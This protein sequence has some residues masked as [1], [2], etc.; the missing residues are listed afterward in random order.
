M[1]FGA[2]EEAGEWVVG[3]EEDRELL[4][5]QTGEMSGKEG[6]RSARETSGQGLSATEPNN[7]NV[8]PCNFPLSRP[9]VTASP[10]S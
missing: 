6:R 2:G 8:A 7:K 9:T 5:S 10:D 1:V 4:A 3:E